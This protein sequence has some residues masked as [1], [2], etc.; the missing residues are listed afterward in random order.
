MTSTTPYEVLMPLA[1]WEQPDVLALSLDS[2]CQQQPP[3]QRLIL[4]VDGPLPAI[5]RSVIQKHWPL[6]IK[7]VCGQGSDGVGLVLDR[8]LA[9]CSCEL[10]LRADS[11]DLS[12]PH[13]AAKQLAWMAASPEV[14]AGSSWIQEF[15]ETPEQIVGCRFV[16]T[17]RKVKTWARWRNPLNHPAVVLRR[18]AVLAV[19]GYRDK[20]GFEDYD[21]W[22]RLLHHYGPPAINNMPEALVLARVGEAHLE[23]RRG[24]HYAKAEAQFFLS[25]AQEKTL[26]WPQALLVLCLRLPWRLL[27]RRTL[28]GLMQNMRRVKA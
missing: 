27:P 12:L 28:E 21:L 23:R 24:F 20:P 6:P 26:S 11:D 16:P 5:L 18:S 1:P 3:P 8:G 22:L 15:I 7:L 2:L 9:E 4:S 13:R 10:I 25:C 19:G 17:G 14:M